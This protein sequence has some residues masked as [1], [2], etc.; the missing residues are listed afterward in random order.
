MHTRFYIRHVLNDYDGTP[1]EFCYKTLFCSTSPMD[2]VFLASLPLSVYSAV[3][4][5]APFFEVGIGAYL[6]RRVRIYGLIPLLLLSFTYNVLICYKALFDLCVS[7]VVGNR[8]SVWTKTLHNGRGNKYIL[9]NVYFQQSSFSI[10]V[11]TFNV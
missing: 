5:F 7:R 4:N 8:R 6:D 11:T 9:C 10:D 1:I 3:G 2:Y